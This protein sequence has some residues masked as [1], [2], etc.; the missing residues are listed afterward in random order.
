MK[1]LCFL[2]QPA[3]GLRPASPV[4]PRGGRPSARP[5]SAPAQRPPTRGRRAP[6]TRAAALWAALAAAGFLAV[7]ALAPAVA[8]AA[9]PPP[10]APQGGQAAAPPSSEM[11]APP[12]ARSPAAGGEEKTAPPGLENEPPPA[13]PREGGTPT[14]PP[15]EGEAPSPPRQKGEAPSPPAGKAGPEPKP[16]EPVPGEAPGEPSREPSQAPGE[17]P[18]TPGAGP[19]PG[20]ETPPPARAE[21]EAGAP[22]PPPPPKPG[23]PIALNFKDAS[24]HAVLEFLSEATGLVILQDEPIEGRITL[25]SRHPLSTDEAVNLLDSV[26]REKGYAAVRIGRTLKVVPLERAPRENL[27]VF[28][29]NDPEAIPPTDRLV[30]QVIPVRYVDATRLRTDLAPL[31]GE[32]ATLSANAASNA[33]VLVDTQA[34]IR[35]IVQIVR[36]LDAHMAGDAEIKVFQLE[37]ADATSTANLITTLFKPEQEQGGQSARRFFPFPFGRGRDERGRSQQGETGRQQRVIASA[38]TRTNA[39]VVSAPPDVMPVIEGIIKELDSNPSEEQSFFIYP[40]KNADAKNVES[41]LNAV[42]SEYAT[43]GTAARTVPGGGPGGRPMIGP[44]RAT[45]LQ[46]AGGGTSDLVGQVYC[47]A[48]EDTNSIIVRAASKHFDRIKAMLDELD[49]PVPQVLIKVLIAEVTHEDQLDLGTEFSILNTQMTGTLNLTGDLGGTDE[50][51]GGLVTATVTTNLAATFNALQREGR[52]DVLSRPYILASDNQEATITVGQEVPF[53]RNSR[54]TETG[55]TINT[56][57]YEDVGIILTVTPHVNPEGLVI[58]DVVPEISTITDTT[59][60]ISET[61]NA[62]VYAKRSAQTRVA[63]HNGQTIVIGGLMEDRITDSVRKVPILGDI[64][65][66]G[67]L[68]KSVDKDKTKTELLI[69]LTPHVAQQPS[70]LPAMSEDETAGAKAVRGAGGTGAFE[71]HLEGMKRGATPKTDADKP[72]GPVVIPG[73]SDDEDEE[74]PDK[75]SAEPSPAAPAAAKP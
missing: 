36:A 34:N 2:T 55:Q 17:A 39:V 65:L 7:A 33:L 46:R 30:T 73:T 32:S 74:P 4:E 69:F 48:D 43:P 18:G 67:E 16:A 53:I 63:I 71:E 60:P 12:P 72:T 70:Q 14:P 51:P 24:V 66:L 22:E 25:I 75:P 40:L 29:G 13:P 68:F 52:L 31:I 50:R 61:V 44:V 37:Y 27:P 3:A 47:V 42:F 10:T 58:M 35:R 28:T 5:G 9:E 20:A 6:P 57:E 41:V 38:D 54:T 62:T 64:P 56:I 49:R 19:A 26:L 15:Q 21:G 23:E 8:R 1:R 45:S 11:P 59:V